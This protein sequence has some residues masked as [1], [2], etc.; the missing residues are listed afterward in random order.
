MCLYCVY[1]AFQMNTADVVPQK[2]L[3]K[4]A[5]EYYYKKVGQDQNAPRKGQAVVEARGA[6]ERAV[7]FSSITHPDAANHQRLPEQWHL[8]SATRDVA[9]HACMIYALI[10]APVINLCAESINIFDLVNCYRV[11]IQ[12]S[13]WQRHSRG[14]VFCNHNCTIFG[15]LHQ[16]VA[17]SNTSTR[18]I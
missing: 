18:N 13:I 5:L 1:A 4:D 16:I 11:Y 17:S 10:T 8:C 12:C 9:L 2:V 14:S 3:A 15:D 7:D 6:D